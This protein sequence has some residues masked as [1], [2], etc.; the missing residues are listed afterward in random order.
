MFIAVFGW[1]TLTMP[2]GIMEG[3]NSKWKCL[4]LQVGEDK[5]MD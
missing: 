4:Q 2:I 1:K 3:W 5:I